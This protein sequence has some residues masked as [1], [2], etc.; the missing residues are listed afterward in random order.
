MLRAVAER[1]DSDQFEMDPIAASEALSAPDS[2]HALMP[3]GY[4]Y[5]SYAQEDFRPRRLKFTNIPDA[6]GNGPIGSAVGGTGIAVSAFT[7]YPDQAIAYTYWVAG[8]EVQQSIYA[9]AGGQ[10][11]HGLAWENGTVN[12]PV[13]NFYRDTRA[14]LEGGYIRPR[15]NGYMEFQDAASRRIN[16]GLL[17]STPAA[18]IV[19]ELNALFRG[20]F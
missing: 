3:L 4:G 16:Q 11:G 9:Q 5:L 18:E 6:G 1:I 13:D 2:P 17:N 20:S 14:T 7:K 8:A 12:A 19:A 15:H 10:P